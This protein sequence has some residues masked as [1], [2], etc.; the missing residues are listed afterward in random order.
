MTWG[1][2]AHLRDLFDGRLDLSI[3][4]TVLPIAQVM[5][6]D[7]IVDHYLS[8]FPPLVVARRTLEGDGRWAEAEP[9][10]RAAIAAMIDTPPEYLV[11]TGTKR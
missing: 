10:I 1:T 11:V 3:E 8:V 5:P 7:R 4:R 2:E 6:K 9:G